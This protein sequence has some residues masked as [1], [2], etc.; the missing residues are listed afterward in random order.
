MT[1]L[2]CSI[3]S[4]MKIWEHCKVYSFLDVN[5]IYSMSSYMYNYLRLEFIC[6]KDDNIG[7]SVTYDIKKGVLV[8]SVWQELDSMSRVQ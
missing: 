3:V 1:V 2:Q 8:P 4:G 7:H 6:T 5:N